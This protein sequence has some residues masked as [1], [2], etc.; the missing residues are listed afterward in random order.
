MQQYRMLELSYQAP[1]PTGS[2]VDVDLSATF[3]CQGQSKTVKGFYAGDGQYRVRFYPSLSGEYHYEV[4]GLVKDQG[5]LTCEPA[6]GEHGMVRAAGTH[7]KY[8]DG[9]WFY[10]FGTTVYA[11][12]HQ[13]AEL[14]AETLNTLAHS[15]F[16]KIRFCVFP[17]HYQYNHNDP[18]WFP[19]EKTADGWD[20]DHPVPAFW[21]HLDAVM[22]RLGEMNIQADL[23]LMH[24]YDCWGFAKLTP[25]QVKTY[26]E[27]VVRRYAAFPNLWWSLAN[28]YDLME[29]TKA[30]WE[31]FAAQIGSQ[32]PFHHLLSNHH[33]VI[34]WDFN[35]ADTTHICVQTQDVD[36]V[37]REINKYQKPMMVDECRYEGNVPQEWGNISGFE[38]VNRF[39]K[40]VTQG[41]YCT[42]GETFLDENDVLW[43]A[44]GGKLKGQSPA[45][46]G[47]LKEIVDNL[48]GPLTFAGQDFDEAKF[49]GLKQ[50]LLNGDTFSSQSPFVKF[51]VSL[52]WK[53]AEKLLNGNREFVGKCQDDQAFLKYFGRDCTAKGSIKLPTDHHYA[54]DVI[55]SWEM[56]K[57]RVVEG[58]N[59]DV[60]VELPGKEGMAILAL[61]MPE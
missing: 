31:N 36:A 32:D 23:I 14:E 18:Q 34:P 25:A 24:S 30:D 17:K 22:K 27:Y 8:D 1:A 41:A 16:N 4:R 10:P 35:N 58:V 44:K 2:A 43:W 38:M 20:V 49:N 50:Q 42:H 54:I 13:T 52:E 33:M 47:F 56:T 59:G 39:W 28:E 61:A 15:P 48:P 60:T 5:T 45:R 9:Q 51:V 37:S 29:Y 53:D 21:D 55:D 46:I 12:I 57:H 3:E 11:M 40:V 7:F 26:L 19:F 6:E